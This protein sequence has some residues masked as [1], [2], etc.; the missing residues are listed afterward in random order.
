MHDS[1]TFFREAHQ[2]MICD[3]HRFASLPVPLMVL[4]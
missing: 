4:G 2:L 3:I 1:Q